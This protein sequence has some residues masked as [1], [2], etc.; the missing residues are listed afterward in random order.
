MGSRMT[1]CAAIVAALC[2]SV[3]SRLPPALANMPS[4]RAASRRSTGWRYNSAPR[5]S[6]ISTRRRMGFLLLP[7][8]VKVLVIEL[9]VIELELEELLLLLAAADAASM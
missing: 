1:S 7:S 2:I 3:A 8:D 6:L 9:L 4:I 5:G